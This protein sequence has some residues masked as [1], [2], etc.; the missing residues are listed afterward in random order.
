MHR[1]G[2]AVV[3][4]LC[5]HTATCLVRHGLHRRPRFA[6]LNIGQT[7]SSVGIT[8][9][10]STIFT[11]RV[12]IGTPAQTFTAMF[13]TGSFETWAPAAPTCVSRGFCSTGFTIASS[14]TSQQ[15]APPT[16]FEVRPRPFVALRLSPFVTTRARVCTQVRYVS[17]T[18]D[19]TAFS[20]YV[21]IGSLSTGAR[22][23]LGLVTYQRGFPSPHEFDG[24]VGMG[25]NSS[26]LQGVLDVAVR[27]NGGEARQFSFYLSDDNAP[28]SGELTIGGFDPAHTSSNLSWVPC[29][30][31]QSAWDLPYW[32]V[33]AVT[34][35][36]GGVQF[37]AAPAVVDSGTSFI[38]A[39]GA[40]AAQIYA[41]AGNAVDQNGSV[42]CWHV[43]TLPT[44]TVTF[45]DTTFTL[46]PEQYAYRADTFSC[47]IGIENGGDSA[48]AWILGDAFMAN[49]LTVFSFEDPSIPNPARPATLSQV[50]GPLA[51]H[52]WVGFG[53]VA[54]AR[55]AR[56]PA[57]T[58]FNSY[59]F[60]VLLIVV[61]AT[62]VVFAI[63]CLYYKCRRR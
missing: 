63:S 14:T 25:P 36:Y 43:L 41:A 27:G 26:A 1:I 20:D 31:S 48:D 59:Q 13:D 5:A 29:R 50:P 58:W 4:V 42:E 15:P 54:P 49:Y 53:T 62:L 46:G 33:P 61:G 17:S 30:P 60:R 57:P 52:H 38:V 19:G 28:T 8:N 24:L 12:S 44:L 23:P 37:P 35:A 34:F 9:Q 3:L 21:Q 6:P 10:Q 39:P 56:F 32:V 40:V 47:F 55:P 16:P 2:A 51:V 18:V 11:G 45:G 22:V 7:T